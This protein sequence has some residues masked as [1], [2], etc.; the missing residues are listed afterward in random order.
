[1]FSTSS[2]RAH[3]LSGALAPVRLQL[4]CI[5]SYAA[6]LAIELVTRYLFGVVLWPSSVE[7]VTLHF[8]TL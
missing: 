1:V 7:L 6:Y 8:S 5:L 3:F 2:A 4:V